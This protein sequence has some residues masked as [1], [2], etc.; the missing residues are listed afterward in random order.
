M[1]SIVKFYM[2]PGT[3]PESFL[4]GCG[5]SERLI[6]PFRAYK[7]MPPLQPYTYFISYSSQEE[8][9]VLHLRLRMRVEQLRVWFASENIMDGRRPHKQMEEAIRVYDKLVLI[10]SEHSIH[11]EWM[12]DELRR[13]RH[14]EIQAQ[15]RKLFPIS[16]IDF[17]ALQ[18]WECIDSR[19][20]S[21]LADEVRAYHI[22]DFSRWNDHDAF[23]RAFAWLLRDLK[24]TDAPPA[25]AP[26]PV[27]LLAPVRQ[28]TALS[29]EEIAQQQAYLSTHRRT[30]ASYL[31]RLGILTTAHAP[32]EITHGIDEARANIARVKAILRASGAQ[33][34][35]HPDDAAD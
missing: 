34:A 27:Q 2:S 7:G 25:P 24:A 5:V 19:T 32:P 33:V 3:I 4:R 35:D 9:F 28:T 1:V 30:L 10:L 11:S 26:Q 16:L 22:P 8:A 23:E 20:G 17:D 18:E 31:Q 13:A 6:V 14:A 21:D 15:R 29:P 12:Q